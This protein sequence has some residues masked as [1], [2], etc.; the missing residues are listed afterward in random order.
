MTASQDKNRDNQQ[1]ENRKYT[2]EEYFDFRSTAERR[3][4]YHDGQIIPVTSATE[5]HGR[6]VSNLVYLLQSCLRNTD[7]DVYASDRDVYSEACNRI[8]YPDL[9]VICGKK[10]T[11]KYS[12]NVVV[13]LNPTILIEVLSDS[14]K[15]FDKTTKK[16]CYRKIDSLRQYVLISQ[17]EKFIEIL[18]R[19]NASEKSWK[20]HFYEEGDEIVKIGD[21][22]VLLEDIY[23][24]VELAKGEPKSDN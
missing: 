17:D 16:N 7:C 13:T 23:H 3:F 14:T 21:C 9:T 24:K 6:I 15:R 5:N 1:P 8:F 12:E 2:L 22:K 19:D 20:T 11:M 10:E 18:E 4:E